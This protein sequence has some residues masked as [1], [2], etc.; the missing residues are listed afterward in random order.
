[1]FLKNMSMF[2]KNVFM[3]LGKLPNLIEETFSPYRLH[4]CFEQL[5]FSE[6]PAQGSGRRQ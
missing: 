5:S 4:D 1:M 6:Q 3:F 2:F